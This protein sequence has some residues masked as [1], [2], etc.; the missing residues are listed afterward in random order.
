MSATD[1]AAAEVDRR[2]ADLRHALAAQPFAF[3]RRFLFRALAMGHS[4]FAELI[5]A[6][7]PEH[8]GELGLRQHDPGG[9][10]SPRTGSEPAAAAA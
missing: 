8:A 1:Q 4:Q 9:L 6:R 3:D 5:G 10:R 7:G 2:I